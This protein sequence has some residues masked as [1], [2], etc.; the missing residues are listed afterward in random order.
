MRAIDRK[1]GE[2]VRRNREHVQ[3]IG[4]KGGAVQTSKGEGEP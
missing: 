3:A 1:G 4:R 2:A